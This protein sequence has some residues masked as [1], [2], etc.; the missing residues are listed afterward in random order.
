MSESFETLKNSL[1]KL[2]SVGAKAAERI[3]LHLLLENQNFAK[4]L[5]NNIESALDKIDRC[6]DC[7]GLS[8]KDC[9]CKICADASRNPDLLCIVESVSD[10]MSIEKSGAWRGKY[11]VLGGKLSPMKRVSPESLRF[12]KIKE[13]VERNSIKEIILALSND[14]EGEATC[15][16][17]QECVIKESSVKLSRIGFGLP[18]GS[19]LG[20]A[21][22]L[23]IK[24]ALDARKSY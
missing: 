23:T 16:Y 15:H 13:L 9:V 4:E 20:F 17:I 14:M 8:T 24:S 22:S 19:Q 21:D 7:G 5:V 3:A 6:P 2:P 11:L 12:A 18:S 10:L 1:R